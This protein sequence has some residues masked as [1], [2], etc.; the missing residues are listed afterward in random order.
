[1]RHWKKTIFIIVLIL[2]II[3]LIGYFNYGLFTPYSSLQ[4]KRDIKNGLIQIIVY[5]EL[6]VNEEL[7][8]SVA[9]KYGFR[10]KRVNDCNVNQIVI[11]GIDCYNRIVKGFLIKAHGKNWESKFNEQLDKELKRNK[12]Q[13]LQKSIE[14]GDASVEITTLLIDNQQNDTIILSKSK[15]HDLPAPNYFFSQEFS[16]L[17]Y[18]TSDYGQNS[19]LTFYE[20][21]KKI[22]LSEISGV[23]SVDKKYA[24]NYWDAT[25]EILFYYDFGN[26]DKGIFPS[27]N[28]YDLKSQKTDKLYG[29]KQYFEID[30][31]T[32]KTDMENRTITIENNY[33]KY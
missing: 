17:I 2:A 5:G 33:I 14:V 30:I 23:I 11:N 27:I 16:Y 31:P 1:M 9:E 10:F 22:K 28:K 32:I 12:F 19:V 6:G 4:A 3:G 29:F 25:N 15:R 21:D 7:E 13:I 18:E 8:N 26:P 20:L 24:E